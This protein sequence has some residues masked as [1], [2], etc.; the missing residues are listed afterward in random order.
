M[1]DWYLSSAVFSAI[2]AFIISHAYSVGDLVRRTTGET[3]FNRHVWRCTTAGTSAGSEPTWTS[4][5]NDGQTFTSNTAVFTSVTGR[6]AQGWTAAAGD[7]G[8]LNNDGAGTARIAA[9]DRVFV[10]SDHAET[11]TG[12]TVT[13]SGVPGA[14]FSGPADIISVDRAGSTP[15]VLADYE[16]G[17]TF[18]TATGSLFLQDGAVWHGCNFTPASTFFLNSSGR[19]KDLVIKDGLLTCVSVLSLGADI[20]LTLDNSQVKFDTTARYIGSVSGANLDLLW[21]DTAVPLVGPTYPTVL[22][23]G[24]S[25][26]VSI[27]AVLRGLDLSA[28]G[29]STSLVRASNTVPQRILLDSCKIDPTVGRV[30]GTSSTAQFSLELVNCYDGTNIINERY[31]PAGSV[32]TERSITLVGGASDGAAFAH[33][34]VSGTTIHKRCTP[35]DGFVMDV[36]NG[37]TGVSQTATVEIISSGSLNDDEISLDLEY[38]PTSGSSLADFASTLSDVLSTPA[39]V[40]TATASWAM[41]PATPVKQ[42]LVATFTAQQAGR[43][44]GIVRLGKASTTAYYNPQ[45]TV[46]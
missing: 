18:A 33:K 29:S 11:L 5:D 40:T 34:M 14:T 44:R 37:V 9:G 20:K 17:A 28:L 24:A 38:Y 36:Y 3:Q 16:P 4:A 1:T 42:K 8:T 27:N 6:A 43:L 22:F 23:G 31:G 13:L 12:G 21:K 25:N 45:M 7:W 32:V 10:S 19:Y 39:A 2:P 41:S 46:A 35:L 30:T 15:P 26:I